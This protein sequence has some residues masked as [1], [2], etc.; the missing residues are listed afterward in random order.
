MKQN[1]EILRK[2]VTL[3]PHSLSK[4]YLSTKFQDLAIVILHQTQSRESHINNKGF[5]SIVE[6][7]V[8]FILKLV[9][10][11][12]NHISNSIKKIISIKKCN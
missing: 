5:C 7:L 4:K 9:K 1:F 8:G 11:H 10:V 2:D 12:K 3:K 6:F